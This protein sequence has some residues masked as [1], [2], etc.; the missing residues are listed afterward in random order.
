MTKIYGHYGLTGKI[1][2]LDIEEG[3][4]LIFDSNDFLMER[5]VRIFI[6]PILSSLSHNINPIFQF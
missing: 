4:E 5:I 2:K 6:I 3:M 1:G